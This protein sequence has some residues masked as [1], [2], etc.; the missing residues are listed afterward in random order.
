MSRGT[1][2]FRP[3]SSVGASVGSDSTWTKSRRPAIRRERRTLAIDDLDNVLELAFQEWTKSECAKDVKGL[4]RLLSTQIAKQSIHTGVYSK[5]DKLWNSKW[6]SSHIPKDQKDVILLS[7]DPDGKEPLAIIQVGTRN[8]EWWTT[9]QRGNDRVVVLLAPLKEEEQMQRE[10]ILFVTLTIENN[11]ESN[12]IASKLGV[13]LCYPSSR[14]QYRMS[15]LRNSHSKTLMEASKAFG[16]F[17]RTTYS[18]DIW[19]QDEEAIY[20]DYQPLSSSCCLVNGSRVSMILCC[21]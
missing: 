3:R 20:N 14:R 11:M 2:G 21:V 10:P 12:S 1:P 8:E 15:L 17:L 4:T 13:F 7:R 9:F 16:R 18:F 5:T 19:I 6:S